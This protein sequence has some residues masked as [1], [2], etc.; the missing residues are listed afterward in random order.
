MLP[1]QP[2]TSFKTFTCSSGLIIPFIA[3]RSTDSLLPKQ[4][5][6]L[7]NTVMIV[8]YM[9]TG[10]IGTLYKEVFVDKEFVS[11]IA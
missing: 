3:S 10:N 5:T 2:M 9:S 1:I 8:D 11:Q 4:L 7:R 6:K